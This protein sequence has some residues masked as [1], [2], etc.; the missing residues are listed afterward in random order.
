MAAPVSVAVTTVSGD[1]T[2]Y[3]SGSGTLRRD[4]RG[5]HLTYSYAENG[6]VV[7]SQLHLGLG[8]AMIV[9]PSYRLLLDPD[10]P[11]QTQLI[12]ESGTLPLNVETHRV[13]ADLCGDAGAIT[14]HYTLLA[15]G[16]PLQ[17]MRVTLALAPTDKERTL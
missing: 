9:T 12:A 16:R 8:R 4:E 1:E 2:L 14:L 10:H 15:Q 3:F 6:S 17:T 7:S 13:H 11:T 5:V